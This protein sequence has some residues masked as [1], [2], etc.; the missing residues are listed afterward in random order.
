MTNEQTD[1]YNRVLALIL[2][3]SGLTHNW[4]IYLL[5]RRYDSEPALRNKIFCILVSGLL[6]AA[7]EY[8]NRIQGLKNEARKINSKSCLHYLGDFSSYIEWI[9]DLLST[10]SREEMI[11][12]SGFRDEILHG[13]LDEIHKAMRLVRYVRNGKVV[14]E[15]VD[16]KYYNEVTWS[17]LASGSIDKAIYPLREKFSAYNSMF[18]IINSSMRNPQRVSML[19]SDLALHDAFVAPRLSR[20]PIVNDPEISKHPQNKSLNYISKTAQFLSGGVEDEDPVAPSRK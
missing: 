17:L 16:R 6:D 13:Y 11:L 4:M 1:L 3:V 12:I 5:D 9:V 7:Q 15:K 14:R 10:F 18:W 20:M 2:V 8:E 19:E